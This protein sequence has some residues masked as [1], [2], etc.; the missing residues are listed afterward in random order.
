MDTIQH[1]GVKGMKW[2][3]RRF[4]R[5]P[6]GK[7]HKGKF[8]GKTK[9]RASQVSGKISKAYNDRV[10]KHEKRYIKDGVDPKQAK[11]LAKKRVKA[12]MVLA[13]A[14]TAGV[15]YGVNQGTKA[16]GRNFIDKTVDTPLQTLNIQG[17]RD[18]SK[19]FYATFNKRDNVKYE[20]L[21]GGLHLGGA[22]EGSNPVFK[23]MLK[24]DNPIKIASHNS[25]RKALQEAAKDATNPQFKEL[26]GAA[27]ITNGKIS[28]KQYHAFNKSL[29]N[30][31]SLD[32]NTGSDYVSP[33]YNQL[34]KQGYNGLLDINDQKFSGFAAKNPA[35]I[36]DKGK[37][38]VETVAQLPQSQLAN[39]AKKEAGILLAR[40]ASKTTIA[41]AIALSTNSV[42]N[43]E[44]AAQE[45]GR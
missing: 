20:G 45:E 11:E 34:K 2:G 29:V 44:I 36:F 18:L 10:S 31:H 27:G 26:L 7:G 4:Q 6:K 40:S 42:L 38:V 9:E 37:N 19:P 16:I 1:H 15:I 41:G 13:A 17:D 8:L 30:A 39:K 35:I 22:A 43:V 23:Q 12:E 32:F 24:G 5:Y 14:A 3:V 21:F 28:M 25:A 33:F